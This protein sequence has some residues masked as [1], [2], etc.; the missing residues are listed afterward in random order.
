MTKLINA[1]RA[2]GTDDDR[3]SAGATVGFYTYETSA[4]SAAK[5]YGYYGGNGRAVPV[6]LLVVEDR[7][8]VLDRAYPEGLSMA[9][10]NK[11]LIDDRRN[12]RAA[13]KAKLEA[14]LTPEEIKLLG[15][16]S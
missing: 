1:W 4:E 15:I 6:R 12:A 9:D 7:F 14:T 2:V 8:Y 11:D 5:G 16:K 3:G 13:A 10:M